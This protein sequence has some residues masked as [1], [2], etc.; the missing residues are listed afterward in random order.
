MVI[1]EGQLYYD[2]TKNRVINIR[3]VGNFLCEVG[4]AEYVSDSKTTI[5]TS[6]MCKWHI[7]HKCVLIE[8]F[9]YS[10]YLEYCNTIDAWKVKKERKECGC[11][12]CYDD[13]WEHCR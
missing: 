7:G 2:K 9:E 1:K 12:G 13:L 10:P 5:C 3:S 8:C 4:I 6:Q 11:C